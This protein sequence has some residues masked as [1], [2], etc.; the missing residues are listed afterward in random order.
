M[1]SA[2]DAIQPFH[3]RMPV[4]LEKDEWQQWL[5]VDAE[6]ALTFVASMPSARIEVIATQES[7]VR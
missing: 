4:L 3:E 1:T 5:T 2:N 7:W 6:Q